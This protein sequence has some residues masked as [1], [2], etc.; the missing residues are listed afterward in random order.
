MR[1][2]Y[3]EGRGRQEGKIS[4]HLPPTYL[5]TILLVWVELCDIFEMEMI[6]PSAGGL[7]GTGDAQ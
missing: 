2:G 3:S 4:S 6:W 1:H 7:D 5:P